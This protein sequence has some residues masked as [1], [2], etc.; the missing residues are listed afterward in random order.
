MGTKCNRNVTAIFGPP[1]VTENLK[2]A[3]IMR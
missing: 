2:F 3:R 1:Y